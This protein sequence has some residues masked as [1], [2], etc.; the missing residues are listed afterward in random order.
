[1]SGQQGAGAAVEQKH[2]QPAIQGSSG[3]CHIHPCGKKWYALYVKSRS[4]FVTNDELRRKGI[5]TFLPTITRPRQWKDR[6]R[7]I[8]FPLFAGYL[9]F[10]V[11]ADH[12]SF[13]TVLKTKGAVTIISLEPGHP[14]PVPDAEI[15]S[16]KVVIENCGDIDIYPH[17]SKGTQV[18]MRSGPL[19]GAEG[20]VQRK[21]DQYLFTVN[22]ELLGRSVRVKVFAEDVE[23]L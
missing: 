20:T 9:F 3:G 23:L 8:E 17:L 5:E 19:A 16:L 2:W 22:I 4:E 1:M 14:T 7:F 10:S 13:L 21:V 18:K 15:E 6:R 11:S 12:E